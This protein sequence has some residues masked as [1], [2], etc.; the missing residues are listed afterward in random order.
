VENMHDGH[1]NDAP[2]SGTV[3]ADITE[4]APC[5]GRAA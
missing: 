4:P 1:R 2:G 5:C 3:H